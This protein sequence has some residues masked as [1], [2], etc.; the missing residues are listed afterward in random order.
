MTHS[1]QKRKIHLIYQSVRQTPH[2]SAQGQIFPSRKTLQ[3]KKKTT[4]SQTMRHIPLPETK[5][6]KS[7]SHRHP[8]RA[9]PGKIIHHFIVGNC[10][11]SEM[12]SLNFA[13]AARRVIPRSLKRIQLPCTRQRRPGQKQATIS[14][15][16]LPRILPPPVYDT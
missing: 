14:G 12:A 2:R 15:L 4:R 9:A 16:E 1:S 5:C 6:R 10:T 3:K 8:R 13:P 11:P 7:H